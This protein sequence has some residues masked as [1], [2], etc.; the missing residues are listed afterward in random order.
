MALKFWNVILTYV[1]NRKK[2]ILVFLPTL[3]VGGSE[4]VVVTLLQH[5]DRKK[6][7]ITL[8]IV[9]T[10]NEVLISEIPKDVELIDLQCTRVRYALPKVIRLIWKVRPDVVFSTLGYLNLAIALCRNLLPNG[11]RYVARES[12][13]VSE[14]IRKSSYQWLWRLAYRIYYPRFD[15]VICQSTYMAKDLIDNFSIPLKKVNILHNPVNREK[16]LELAVDNSVIL[17][18]KTNINLLAV[19]RLV[20]VKGFD[21]LIEAVALCENLSIR[22]TILG[23][24]PLL[25]EL[26]ELSHRLGVSDRVFFLGF[27]KNPYPYMYQADALVLSSRYEGFPNVV[28]EALACGTPVIATPAPGGV[29]EILNNLEGCVIAKKIDSASLATAISSFIPGAKLPASIVDSYRT[30]YI[31]KEYENEFMKT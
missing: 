1:Y 17:T 18:E 29:K 10:R 4:R 11:I 22:L 2:T 15:S 23:D 3:G 24:G 28:L 27:K 25:T 9:D 12:S 20:N 21:L 19:G 7:Q 5:I 6:F 16:I 30:S 26:H 31:V 14:V 8:A 13:I